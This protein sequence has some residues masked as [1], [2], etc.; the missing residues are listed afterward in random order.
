MKLYS[1]KFCFDVFPLSDS[2][3]KSTF[4]FVLLFSRVN[5]FKQENTVLLGRILQYDLTFPFVLNGVST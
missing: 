1:I 2:W 5:L 3:E 4:N